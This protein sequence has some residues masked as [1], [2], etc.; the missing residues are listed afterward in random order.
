MATKAAAPPTQ[1][2]TGLVGQLASAGYTFPF[3]I[4]A[5]VK[6]SIKNGGADPFSYFY[7]KLI[8]SKPF[9]H[10]FP[11]I[12]RPDGT[13]RMSPAQYQQYQD[14]VMAAAKKNGFALSKAAVGNL[15]AND[16]S[17][18]EFSFRLQAA[19]TIKSNPDLFASFNSILAS[20]G[21][22]Q[23]KTAQDAF[24]FLAGKAPKSVYDTYE[25]A[26]FEAS[27]KAAGVDV[28]AARA[29]QLAAGTAG[30][31]DIGDIQ[32]GYADIA[33]KLRQ[34]GVE[35]SGVGL[36]QA[37]LETIEFGGANQAALAAKAQQ[38][39][40]NQQASQQNPLTGEEVNLTKGGQ[41]VFG[42]TT[43]AGA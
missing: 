23:I 6:D 42:T 18:D 38:A 9:K 40:K 41:P 5:L 10:Y 13:L 24:N 34:S 28:N 20:N 19:Q 33:D 25:A 37:D 27:A 8:Q 2:K 7:A 1:T 17:T 32:K 21:Q 26:T 11:G 15:I 43:K 29:K 30:M 16:V 39:L 12:Q 14:G 3:D 35:L 4:S 36:S 31:T 22:K